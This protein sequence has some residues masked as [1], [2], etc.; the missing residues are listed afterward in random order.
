MSDGYQK[1]RLTSYLSGA[2]EKAISD[3]GTDWK[4]KGL[5]LEAVAE[6]LQKRGPELAAKLGTTSQTAAELNSS[7]L[8]SASS[9]QDTGSKL[10]EAGV[11][12][13][14][15]GDNLEKARVSRKA[16]KTLVE[17]PPFTAPNY[18]GAQPTPEQIQ[19]EANQRAASNS[20]HSSYQTAYAG[21]EAEAAEITANLDQ[22]FLSAIPPMMAIHGG[23]DP[24]APTPGDKDGPGTTAPPPVNRTRDRG[25]FVRPMFEL[26]SVEDSEEQEARER[27]REREQREQME[28]E[29]QRQRELAER[30]RLEQERL[31]RERLERERLERER[32]ERL[33]EQETGVTT[34]HPTTNVVGGTDSGAYYQGVSD[35]ASTSGSATGTS[36]GV[37]GAAA[38]G[39]AGAGLGAGAMKG[40]AIG[41]SAA[42]PIGGTVRGIGAGGQPVSSSFSR[43]TA[44]GARGGAVSGST[45]SSTAGRSTAAGSASRSAGAGGRAG[46]TGSS[47]AAR[48]NGGASRGSAARAGAAGSTSGKGSAKGKGKGLF[49]R[50]SNGSTAG[51]RSNKSGDDRSAPRDALVYEQ[52]WLGD[53]TAAP[54][55]LD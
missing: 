46:A 5:L 31:E 36:A 24:T 55:V 38:A 51:G 18:N 45:S 53:E 40:G 47:S 7:L 19:Q 39:A 14:L 49:R 50:G 32:L 9:M 12:L 43:S 21:Q 26:H 34:K 42:A 13:V 35:G 48:G 17:P 20:E 2:N 27:E 11:A 15:V 52:D 41:G 25:V 10:K 1:Q 54:S 23:P 44:A 16:M 29:R 28:R 37:G 4:N 22:A 6:A 8:A 30:E 3:S 33:R